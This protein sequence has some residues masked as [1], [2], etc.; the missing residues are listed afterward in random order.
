MS[1]T[2]V[3]KQSRTA[4]IERL[5]AKY[6]GWATFTPSLIG[7]K[8]VQVLENDQWNK[9]GALRKSKAIPDGRAAKTV[10]RYRQGIFKSFESLLY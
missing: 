1:T 2:W 10:Y 7:T 5:R 9:G 4:Q 6:V 8:K 3:R